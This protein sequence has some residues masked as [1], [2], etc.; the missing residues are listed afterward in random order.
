MSALPGLINSL[1]ML[2]IRMSRGLWKDCGT[3]RRGG[4]IWWNRPLGRIAQRWRILA[5]CCPSPD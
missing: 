3:F 2:E 1:S 5:S 4:R